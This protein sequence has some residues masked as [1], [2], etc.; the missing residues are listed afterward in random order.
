MKKQHQIWLE[1]FLQNCEQHNLSKHTIKSYFSDLRQFIKWVEFSLGLS[2]AKIRPQHIALYKQFMAGESFKYHQKPLIKLSHF[3]KISLFRI[4]LIFKQKPHHAKV[5]FERK[6]SIKN[7]S[8]SSRRRKLSAI[9]NF[10]SFLE[11]FYSENKH[12]FN[13]VPVKQKLHAIKLKDEDVE[14]TKLLT[15]DD[16]R[17]LCEYTWRPKEKLVLNLLYYGGLRLSELVGL[18]FS[19]FHEESGTVRLR[20]KGGHIHT[21]GIQQKRKIF[22]CLKRY[23][24][25]RKDQKDEL[26]LGRSHT[27]M[28]S[29]AMYNYLM[30]LFHDSGCHTKGLGP[31]SFR[32]ACATNLYRRTKDLLLVRDY[33]NHQDAKVT[34]TYIS[35]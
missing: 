8:I 14:S 25:T 15:K 32:K 18:S 3:I 31:H 24:E 2:L 4:S 28:S 16:W 26:F 20:R 12:L 5:F 1:Q 29:K 19:D 33:L 27:H 13:D 6:M 10:Y 17:A 22:E 7:L 35:R 23:K 30:K 11:A 9:A 34:Q 21:L